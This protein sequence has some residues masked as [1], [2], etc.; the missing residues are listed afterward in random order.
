[1]GYENI[2]HIQ[3]LKTSFGELLI[4]SFEE[5]VCICDWRYRKNRSIIDKR[6]QEGLNAKYVE[7]ETKIICFAIQQLTEYFRT[8]RKVFDIPL[9]LV[10][11]TFQQIVWNELLKI[12]YGK[13][14]TYLKLSRKIK[15]EKAVRAVASANGA[16]AISI[17]VPCHRVIGSRGELTGYAGGLTAKR[18]LL[19]L[20]SNFQTLEQLKLF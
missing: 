10:G 11:T 7:E 15:N 20:E 18:K 6:I 4:G 19:Q 16:N 14:E 3:F 13:T 2:I 1:M 9:Q 17:I 5:R 8:E 12:P